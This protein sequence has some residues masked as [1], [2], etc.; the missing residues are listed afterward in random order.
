MNFPIHDYPHDY[1]RFTPEAFKLLL[2]PFSNFFVGFQGNKNYPHTVVG[3]GFKGDS[4]P[5]DG[6]TKRYTLWQKND[7]K[8]IR[9]L[10]LKLTPPI[11]LPI[12]AWLYRTVIE[13]TRR[14]T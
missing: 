5:L 7:Y 2:K 12:I 10:A 8:S 11:F 14:S 3:I 1:W 13:Q 6:F 4:K 9:Q